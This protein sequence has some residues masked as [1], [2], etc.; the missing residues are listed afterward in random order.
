VLAGDGDGGVLLQIGMNEISRTIF[1]FQKARNEMHEEVN[2]VMKKDP[3]FS[4]RAFNV[5]HSPFGSAPSR[6]PQHFLGHVYLPTALFVDHVHEPGRLTLPISM[7]VLQTALVS[8]GGLRAER[9]SLRLSALRDIV[10]RMRQT[11]TYVASASQGMQKTRRRSRGG[12]TPD[13]PS[14]LKSAFT[15]CGCLIQLVSVRGSHDPHTCFPHAY[16]CCSP[17]SPQI[18][19]Q[20]VFLVCPESQSLRPPALRCAPLRHTGAFFD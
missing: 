5:P 19:Q 20:S 3:Y 7:R 10:E 8:V 2:K 6:T 13:L 17:P 15:A 12:S 11:A 9:L 14:D 4:P 1:H 16:T 18:R